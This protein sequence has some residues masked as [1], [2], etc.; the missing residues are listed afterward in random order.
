MQATENLLQISNTYRSS[1]KRHCSKIISKSQFYPNIYFF[2]KSRQ[3]C[4]SVQS[5]KNVL[6]VGAGRVAAPLVEYLHRD[7]SI[8]ITVAC[9][10]MDLADGLVKQFPGIESAYIN[11]TEESATLSVTKFT[12]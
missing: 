12:N 1:G 2:R 8:G 5:E 10:Q 4:E 3:K 9:E 11:A 7:K 6:I